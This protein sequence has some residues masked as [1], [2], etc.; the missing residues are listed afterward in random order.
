MARTADPAAIRNILQTDRAWAVYALADLAP[1]YSATARWHVFASGSPALLLLYGG[2]R[3]PV[4]FA[5]GAA[6]DLAPLLSDIA[7]EREF[8][9]SVRPDV[10]ALLLA[11]GYRIH[12][13]K[14]MWRRRSRLS[15]PSRKA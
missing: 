12:A 15:W 7:G 11:N 3:P 8:Y 10:V 14:I 13:E 6:A 2:F 9:L 4:L 1:E 5:H